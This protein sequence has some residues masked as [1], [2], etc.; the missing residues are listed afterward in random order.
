[1]IRGECVCTGFVRLFACGCVRGG[2]Y[3]SCCPQDIGWY[4]FILFF[5]SIVHNNI[6]LQQYVVGSCEL[7]YLREFA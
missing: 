3:A 7:R 4:F 5:F 2:T 1:M 6:D